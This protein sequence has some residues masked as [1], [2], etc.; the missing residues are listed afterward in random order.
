M[1]AI[2]NKWYRRFSAE[3]M[4]VGETLRLNGITI[5]EDH[6]YRIGWKSLKKDIGENEFPHPNNDTITFH[7]YFPE[8]MLK[9]HEDWDKTKQ[10]V[11]IN[12]FSSI[13]D[14]NL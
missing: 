3:D 1:D 2:L 13:K 4:C 7:M 8:F 10:L 11:D 5:T 14:R 6:R 12:N 9:M